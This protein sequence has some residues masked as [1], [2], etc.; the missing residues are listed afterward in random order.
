MTVG[1]NNGVEVFNDPKTGKLLA[2]VIRGNFAGQKYNFLTSPESAMQ[3]GVNSYQSGEKIKAHSHVEREKQI[4]QSQECL[5]L[6][7]GHMLFYIFDA[8]KNLVAKTDLF[9][10][11]I[12]FQSSGGHG[13]EVLADTQII[14]I[15]QGPF[16]GEKDKI[17]FDYETL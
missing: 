5:V 17:R 1:Q 9:A 2:M 13:F 14:E 12:A 6:R 3:L 8:D 10:G 7:K 11:D 16:G 4:F 15:K